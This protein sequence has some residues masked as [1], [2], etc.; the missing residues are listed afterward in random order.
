M[1]ETNAYVLCPIGVVF[2]VAGFFAVWG[3][4]GSWGPSVGCGFGLFNGGVIVGVPIGDIE[5]SGS[6]TS[7]WVFF[8]LPSG[9]G[10]VPVVGGSSWVRRKGAGSV[11]GNRRC[12]G[13]TN[14]DR[15]R[16]G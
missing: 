5:W 7:G 4:D 16:R 10:K 3:D 1:A 2:D 8:D 11:R 9:R 15:K 6:V 13:L 14:S 12:T